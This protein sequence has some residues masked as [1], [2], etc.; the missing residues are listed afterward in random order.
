MLFTLSTFLGISSFQDLYDADSSL[1]RKYEQL[2]EHPS[3]KDL[4]FSE[5]VFTLYSTLVAFITVCTAITCPYYLV[6][7]L[8]II[9]FLYPR[10]NDETSPFFGALYDI[11][12]NL[13]LSFRYNLLILTV[14]APLETNLIL[15]ILNFLYGITSTTI[16]FLFSSLSIPSLPT[17]LFSTNFISAISFKPIINFYSVVKQFSFISLFP[18]IKEALLW[19]IYTLSSHLVP[20]VVSAP[21]LLLT[22]FALLKALHENI[23]LNERPSYHLSQLIKKYYYSCFI[24]I[25][26]PTI[27]YIIINTSMAISNPG[28]IIMYTLIGFSGYIL[29]IPSSLHE[30]SKTIVAFYITNHV[31]QKYLFLISSLAIIHAVIV[32]IA[33]IL[34]FEITIKHLGVKDKFETNVIK[35]IS[36]VANNLILIE[37][38]S[39]FFTNLSLW[40]SNV[41]FSTVI[42]DHLP[43]EQRALWKLLLDSLDRKVPDISTKQVCNLFRTQYT[44]RNIHPHSLHALFTPDTN[45]TP[46][47]GILDPDITF[48][49]AF[50]VANGLLVNGFYVYTDASS[51]G[52]KDWHRYLHRYPMLILF[53]TTALLSGAMTI[54]NLFYAVSCN[55][56]CVD[57]YRLVKKPGETNNEPSEATKVRLVKAQ[58]RILFRSTL[59]TIC[60]QYGLSTNTPVTEVK[61]RLFTLVLCIKRTITSGKT[62]PK[63]GTIKLKTGGELIPGT[64]YHTAIDMIAFYLYSAMPPGALLAPLRKFAPIEFES[65]ETL[66]RIAL[67]LGP[68][69]MVDNHEEKLRL[70]YQYYEDECRSVINSVSFGSPPKHL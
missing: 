31:L 61:N 10:K 1:I 19:P 2:T 12:F 4:S 47:L 27:Y 43:G 59:K 58:L 35:F 44:T 64:N 53:Q 48:K 16:N 51:H 25:L 39:T 29:P 5:I 42:H 28:L 56:W 20:A 17:I 26:I 30:A 14:F 40:L 6:V 65:N 52:Q 54:D 70:C 55:N 63:D 66:D 68:Q 57:Q 45:N 69:P 37:V 62:D 18:S 11:P 60:I 38:L 7:F 50:K 67:G 23:W 9:S 34:I 36:N 15:H 3:W 46:K 49:E 8:Y 22:S 21:L 32:T 33:A 41:S 13:V 24:T